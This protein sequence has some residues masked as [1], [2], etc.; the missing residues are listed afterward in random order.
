MSVCGGYCD[1]A[2]P[3]NNTKNKKCVLKNRFLVPIDL[4]IGLAFLFLH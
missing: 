4:F 1:E 3:M 2:D